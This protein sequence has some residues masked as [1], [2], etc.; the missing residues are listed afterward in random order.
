MSRAEGIAVA[1]T[2]AGRHGG[3]AHGESPVAVLVPC[4]NEEAA[5]ATVVADFRAALPEATDLC[6]R[7]QFDRPHRRGARAAGAVVRR[8][9]HQGKG[10]VVRRMFS[11]VEADIYVLVDGDATYDAPSARG[12][13]RAA[14]ART[15]STWWWPP[16]SISEHGGLSP[17]P[18]DRQPSAHRLRRLGL[19]GDVH[20]HSVG[21]SGVLA[22]LREIVSGAVARL[23][24]RDRA[25]RACARARAARWRRCRRPITRGRRLGIQA[26]DLARRLAHSRDHHQ[27]LSLGAAAGVL[28]RRSASRSRSPRS[29]SRSRSS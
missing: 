23:R 6:L 17:G 9:T 28:L 26:Q 22:P 13:D 18:S 29:A 20:R 2:R 16:A 4:F 1:A 3:H 19:Q 5:I 12:H 7:Q 25:D 24:D 8:E 11:D 27:A 21:L 14:A 15:V 10:N